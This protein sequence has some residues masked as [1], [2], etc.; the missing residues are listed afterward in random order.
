MVSTRAEFLFQIEAAL[1]SERE[2][3]FFCHDLVLMR[4]Q[5]SIRIRPIDKDEPS[6]WLQDALAFAKHARSIVY[7]EK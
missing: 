4:S 2:C 5:I 6:V 7:L 3:L 1:A